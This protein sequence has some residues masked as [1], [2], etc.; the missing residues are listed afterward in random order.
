VLGLFKVDSDLT[1]G[2][3]NDETVRI[4]VITDRKWFESL[5]LTNGLSVLFSAHFEI[6]LLSSSLSFPCSL[7]DMSLISFSISAAS[8]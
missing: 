4:G 5:I 2:F 7:E 8:T 1:G 6:K 3:L